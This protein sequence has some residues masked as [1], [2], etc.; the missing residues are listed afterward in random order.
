MLSPASQPRSIL[1]GED[2]EEERGI[3]TLDEPQVRLLNPMGVRLGPKRAQPLQQQAFAPVAE[4][5]DV[6]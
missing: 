3:E 1:G 2:E 4:P 6:R 5:L